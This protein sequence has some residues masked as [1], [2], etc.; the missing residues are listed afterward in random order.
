MTP[1]AAEKVY[2]GNTVYGGFS[3]PQGTSSSDY[4][5][6]IIDG[7]TISITASYAHKNVSSNNLI[8]FILQGRDA[9]NY[10]IDTTANWQTIALSPDTSYDNAQ[11][12]II[13][14][15]LP[16]T[17]SVNWIG[18]TY[19]VYDGQGIPLWRRRAIW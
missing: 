8:T 1:K 10:L 16:R 7:T 6:K 3:M 9:D 5:G 12:T 11:N 17:V 4:D 19:I 14:V 2:N 15:I 18:D 13:G